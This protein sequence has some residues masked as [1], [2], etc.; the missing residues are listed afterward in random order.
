M[1]KYLLVLLLSLTSLFALEFHSYEDALKL[2]K[3]SGK[4]IMID[5]IRT[6]CHYCE[7]M[8]KDVFQNNEMS[9]W[10]ENRFIP[11]KLNLKN[12]KLPLGIQVHF[13]PTFFFVDTNGKIV[14]K[15]PGSWNIEDF[16]D[17]TKGIK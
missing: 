4:T 14:K 12:D 10:L 1:N 8:D 13:T 17:L 6:D 9:E 2:Q 5:V 7:D 3:K 15:I 11:V 16:K